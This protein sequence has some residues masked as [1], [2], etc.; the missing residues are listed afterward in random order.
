MSKKARARAMR[1]IATLVVVIAI[2]G[3]ASSVLGPKPSPPTDQGQNYDFY[4]C[5]VSIV[6]LRSSGTLSG[7][8]VTLTLQVG[9]NATVKF[10]SNITVVTFWIYSGGNT[11]SPETLEHS[12][13]SMATYTSGNATFYILK[14]Q[15]DSVPTDASSFQLR[16]SWTD[17]RALDSITRNGNMGEGDQSGSHIFGASYSL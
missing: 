7:V 4:K 1:L 10:K 3:I 17:T 14:F 8:N 5:Y 12:P 15:V 6:E 11:T 16:F 13:K 9:L 2:I